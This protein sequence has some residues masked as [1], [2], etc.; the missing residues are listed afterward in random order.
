L[1][2]ELNSE[3]I[4]KNSEDASD[5]YSLLPKDEMIIFE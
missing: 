1:P 5:N 2:G 4:N 3:Y